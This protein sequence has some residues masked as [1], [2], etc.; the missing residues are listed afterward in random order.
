MAVSN[1]DSGG[2]LNLFAGT[3]LS[4]LDSVIAGEYVKNQFNCV[5]LKIT[6]ATLSTLLK[7]FAPKIQEVHFLKGDVEGL[8]N[9]VLAGNEWVVY[10]P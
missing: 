2:E 4:R 5:S 10:L 1:K 8:E 9:E 7:R 3:G 6:T